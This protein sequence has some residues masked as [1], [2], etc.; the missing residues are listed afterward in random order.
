MYHSKMGADVCFN[1]GSP[2]DGLGDKVWAHSYMLMSRSPVFE[3]MVKEEWCG[4]YGDIAPEGI[5]IPDI[6]L[7]AF[8]EMLRCLQLTKQFDEDIDL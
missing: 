4:A 6:D 3:R 2:S 5:D 7:C 1:V 8:N